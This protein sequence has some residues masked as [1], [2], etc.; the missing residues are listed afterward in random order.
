[1][2]RKVITIRAVDSPN[3][4]LALQQQE[5]GQEPSREEVLPGVLTWDEY[6]HRRKTWDPI[7]QA[8]GLDAHWYVGAELK[9]FPRVLMLDVV[10][11]S[12][13][14]PPVGGRRWMGVDPAEG[15]DRSAWVVVD[16][17][18][19]LEMVSE[20]TPNTN[21]VFY[22]T[23]ELMRRWHIDAAD[24]C[25]DRGSGKQHA[26]R[27]AEAGFP[28]RTV[29]FG[30]AVV[31]PIRSG[32][33]TTEERVEAREDQTIYRNRRTE[34]YW[35]AAELLTAVG[36][37]VRGQ[38][39]PPSGREG[40]GFSIPPA[41]AEWR[42]EGRKSLRQQLEVIPREYD[43]DGRPFLRPKNSD[44]GSAESGRRRKSLSELTGHSPD[45]ADAFVLALFAMRSEP[46]VV[47][48]R[49]S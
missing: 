26:D 6:L 5:D 36:S 3:V 35:E 44:P 46:L 47:T 19:V 28:V 25:M 22:R 40:S 29:A 2:L 16:S 41:I 38:W 17:F 39:V 1:M 34:M 24:V 45:E 37:Y 33:R 42:T 7:R 23:I 20:Q 10:A 49:V 4:A 30:E 11:R 27:L 48:A 14:R 18:G 12:S 21:S 43:R 8:V 32:M 31:L 13:T 9:L 15:G